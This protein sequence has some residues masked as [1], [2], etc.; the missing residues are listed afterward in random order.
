MGDD[1]L[2]QID[3]PRKVGIC[4]SIQPVAWAVILCF[5]S[6]K[7][8]SIAGDIIDDSNSL[9][10]VVEEKGH[11]VLRLRFLQRNTGANLVPVVKRS[12]G[13]V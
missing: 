7:G 9:N 2:G 11:S 12:L 13:C 6:D 10:I 5:L 8:Y 1:T 3:M 4:F